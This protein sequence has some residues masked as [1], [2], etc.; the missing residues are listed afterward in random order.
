MFE[1]LKKAMSAN[2]VPS[3]AAIKSELGKQGVFA[4][5]TEQTQ[6]DVLAMLGKA[7]EVDLFRMLHQL[8]AMTAATRDQVVAKLLHP[9]QNGGAEAEAAAEPARTHTVQPGDSL[10]KIAKAHGVSLQQVIAA[11][12]QVKNPDLIHP[13]EVINLPA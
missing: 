1:F 10:S 11:N 4:S 9:G 7:G 13:R 6:K 8:Q 12:P 2:N 5:L 3:L